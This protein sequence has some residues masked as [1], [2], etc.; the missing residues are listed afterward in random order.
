MFPYLDGRDPEIP[1]LELRKVITGFRNSYNNKYLVAYKGSRR[2][3]RLGKDVWSTL[4]A[5]VRFFIGVF[6]P[7]RLCKILWGSTR[8]AVCGPLWD[9]SPRRR[10]DIFF[11]GHVV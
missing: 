2:N 6:S 11:W 3:S 7:R 10:L 9:F 5:V 1:N 4:L 8:P